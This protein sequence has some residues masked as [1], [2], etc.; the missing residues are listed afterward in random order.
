MKGAT[1][2]PLASTSRPPSTMVMAMIGSSQNFLRTLMKRHIWTTNSNN[3]VTKLRVS[4]GACAGV[5]GPPTAACT[6]AVGS[7]PY[8]IAFDGVNIWVANGGGATVTK[9]RAS[10]GACAGIVGPPT[11][12][13]TFAV[14]NFAAA[15]AFDGANVWVTNSSSASVTKL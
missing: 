10:D 9:L 5:V 12:A 6:F 15:V 11:A 13:C 3:N 1:T 4:D 2:E 7:S 14:G 8:G